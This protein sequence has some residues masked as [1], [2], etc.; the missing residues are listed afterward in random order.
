MTNHGSLRRHIKN[1]HEGIKNKN[2]ICEECGKGFST[3]Y[4][5]K[6]HVDGVHKGL[7]PFKCTY[8]TDAFR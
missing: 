5:L 4:W 3:N 6:I 8:C 7:K 2:K 1:V